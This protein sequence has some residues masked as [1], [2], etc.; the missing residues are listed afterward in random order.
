MSLLGSWLVDTLHSPS[1]DWSKV[2]IGGTIFQFAFK[3]LLRFLQ[4]RVQCKPKPPVEAEEYHLTDSETFEKSQRYQRT[5]M[6]FGIVAETFDTAVTCYLLSQQYLTKI[7]YF[8]SGKLAGSTRFGERTVGALS[9]ITATALSTLL[10]IP[11]DLYGTFGVEAKFGFNKSTFGLWL[12]DTIKE[13]L[14]SV[15]MVYGLTYVVQ[16]VID[17]FGTNF[18]PYLLGVMFVIILVA[19]VV[20][21]AFIMPLFNKFE[22]LEDGELRTAI[23]ELAGS[24]KFPLSKLY[25]TD[26]SKRSSHSNAYFIGLPWYKQIVLFDTLI[27]ENTV[28]EV[29]AILAHELGHWKRNHIL[30]QVGMSMGNLAILLC[31]LVPFL[32]NEH[33][34]KSVGFKDGD[35]PVIGALAYYSTAV[36]PLSTL[37]T[38]FVNFFIRTMEFDDDKFATRLGK[39][40]ELS[41]ALAKMSKSS[42]SALEANALYSTYSFSHPIITERLKAIKEENKKLQ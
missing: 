36:T 13:F 41:S 37:L 25:V 10:D 42:L 23:E 39:G 19:Q 8:W 33:F 29:V 5:R 28:E 40:A 26:G 32:N 38:F 14:V 7:F 3:N 15:P 11:S 6:L 2:L 20:F 16:W 22:P 9:I 17:Y 21:P 18:V 31:A 34:Y 27:E 1:I 12:S 35:M 30:A 24:Q 4:Y